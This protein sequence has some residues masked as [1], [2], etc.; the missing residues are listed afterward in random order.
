M[1]AM[2]SRFWFLGL[3]ATSFVLTGCPEVRRPAEGSSA[4]PTTP[5]PAKDTAPAKA[6][7]AKGPVADYGRNLS[8]AEKKATEVTGLV[9]LNQTVQQFNIIEGRNP[10]SLDELV[11]TRYLPSLPAAPRGKRY[12]YNPKEGK[13][14]V[15]DLQPAAPK[16]APEAAPTPEVEAAPAPATGSVSISVPEA[17]PSVENP[18]EPAP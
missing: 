6:S 10:R 17:A 2:K 1:T 9:T 13:V 14:E 5:A 15:Q 12:I 7:E 8:N 11:E 16:P 3:V 4:K 18:A